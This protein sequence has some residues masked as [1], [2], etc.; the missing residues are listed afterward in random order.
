MVSSTR[1]SSPKVRSSHAARKTK[2]FRCEQC[3]RHFARLEYQQRH[4]RTH[5]HEKPFSC[6]QWERDF[7][8][9]DLLVR[10]ERLSHSGSGK[11]NEK[12]GARRSKRPRRSMHTQNGIQ[13]GKYLNAG[14]YEPQS[15]VGIGVSAEETGAQYFQPVYVGSSEATG[16]SLEE[17]NDLSEHL[18]QDGF[19]EQQLNNS[20]DLSPNFSTQFQ[21]QLTETLFSDPFQDLAAFMDNHTPLADD[22]TSFISP[23]QRLDSPLPDHY[24]DTGCITPALGA[25]LG[26]TW[27]TVAVLTARRR[28]TMSSPNSPRSQLTRNVLIARLEQF[29]VVVPESFQMPSRLAMCHYLTDYL[30]GFHEHMPFLQIPTISSEECC[31]ELVLAI[32]SIGAQC[33]FE[34][35][36]TVQLFQASHL[37]SRERT[38]R[39]DALSVYHTSHSDN[40]R[41]SREPSSDNN[42]S[43]Q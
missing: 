10:H 27:V 29:V 43:V 41:L 40:D 11:Q 9:T 22:F 19:P 2:R 21:A 32:A 37:I 20:N 16:I 34:P 23:T 3:D 1:H 15:L 26:T 25:D 24:N 13:N 14:I 17:V 18:N 28:Y 33:C 31:I 7:S 4:E 35:E 42:Q 8:R 36:R 39:H 30:K 6:S 5:T 12:R 38:R